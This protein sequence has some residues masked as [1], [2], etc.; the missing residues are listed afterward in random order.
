M[1]FCSRN[2]GSS[3]NPEEQPVSFTETAACGSA[4]N[5]ALVK[6]IAWVSAGLGVIALGLFA[7]RELR[8]RYKFNRRTPYDFYSHAGDKQDLEA[9]LGI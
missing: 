7:G 9:G 8:L 1:M 4:G 2:R 3:H 6:T 5:T